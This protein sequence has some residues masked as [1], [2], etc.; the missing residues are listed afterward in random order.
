MISPD[1]PFARVLL[2]GV[3]AALIGLLVWR[4]VRK[5]RREYRRFKRF[6]SSAKRQA[7]YRKWLIDSVCFFGGASVVVLGAVW[8]FVP[9][10]R[11]DVESWGWVRGIRSAFDS[12][13]A[14]GVSIVVALI[15]A[16]FGGSVVAIVLA[17]KVDAIPSVGDIQALLPRNRA[18]LG[19]GA[20]LSVNAGVVEE[21]LFRL[22]LPALLFGVTSNAVV[23]II[24]SLMIF[25]TL[26]I[27]QGLPGIIGS[28]IIGI[29]LMAVYLGTGSIIVAILVHAAIDL[30]SLVLIPMIVQGVHR[31]PGDY[32]PP[33]V[34][35]AGPATIAPE[36]PLL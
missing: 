9:L 21:L 13:G 24:G 2:T 18:E 22:A 19:Y 16:L 8:Q 10:L 7:M 36:A 17:R 5:D 3:L 28:T 25:G 4:A 35:R 12:S 1:L 30:R 31:F 14:I 23:A 11:E 6:R 33:P 15:V 20:A 29:F 26:H 32:V 34:R 27:Y